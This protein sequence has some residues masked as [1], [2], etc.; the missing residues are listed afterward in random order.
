MAFEKK[1]KPVSY[2]SSCGRQGL[3]VYTTDLET[4]IQGLSA[5]LAATSIASAFRP[6]TSWSN[7]LSGD[8]F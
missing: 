4:S 1:P 7:S 3:V 5:P 6:I 8:S 2:K